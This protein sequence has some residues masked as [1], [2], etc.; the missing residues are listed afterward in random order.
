MKAVG[1]QFR[2]ALCLPMD[3]T[4]LLISHYRRQFTIYISQSN[5]IPPSQPLRW[6]HPPPRHLL[7]LD[8]GR[9]FYPR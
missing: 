6:Y 5:L 9:D 7:L 2:I 1:L 3:V 8:A 4:A